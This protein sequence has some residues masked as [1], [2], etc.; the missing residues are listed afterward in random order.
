MKDKK[1]NKIDLESV[2]IDKMA[3]KVAEKP[4]SLSFPHSVGGAVIKPEDK[5]KIKGRA[6]SAMKEQTEM[7][8]HQLYEQMHTLALQA[9]AI[10]K[11]V[12]ISERIYLSKM[13]FEP[14]IGHI[15][16]LYEQ[17]DGQDLLSMIAPEE[18]GKDMP[19]KSYLSTVR[20]LADHTWEVL[21]K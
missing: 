9:K 3:E 8:L 19:Y 7:Q 17:K 1:V 5:G 16:Y 10:K 12:E 6:M 21:K 18:W 14:I 13:N 2:D 15:Y 11:R 20:L 4:G